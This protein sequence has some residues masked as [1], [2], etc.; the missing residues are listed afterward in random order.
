M[1]LAKPH[2]WLKTVKKYI[3]KDKIDVW[4]LLIVNFVVILHRFFSK[5]S[6]TY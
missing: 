6:L 5:N 3:I 4:Q 2:F 1:V